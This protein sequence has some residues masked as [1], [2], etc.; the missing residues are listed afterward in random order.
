MTDPCEV[1]GQQD[2]C[3]THDLV[4]YRNASLYSSVLIKSLCLIIDVVFE[5]L[6][7]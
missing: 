1:T 3:A 7:L 6:I 2:C 5:V 4:L